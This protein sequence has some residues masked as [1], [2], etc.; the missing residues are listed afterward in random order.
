MVERGFSTR[1]KG[2]ELTAGEEVVDFLLNGHQV[3]VRSRSRVT[4]WKH[5]LALG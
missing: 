5:L 1:I 3:R 4:E 2:S